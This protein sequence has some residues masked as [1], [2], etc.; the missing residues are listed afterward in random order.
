MIY[1][2]ARGSL[3]TAVSRLVNRSVEHRWTTLQPSQRQALVD[4]RCISFNR[5]SDGIAEGKPVLYQSVKDACSPLIQVV[6]NNDFKSML[7]G[8]RD[9]DN[10]TYVHS[11]RV[12]TYLALF[13]FNLRMSKEEQ[14]LLAGGGLLHDVGK[15]TIPHAVLNKPGTSRRR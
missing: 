7:Q 1:P 9:H 12:A 5:L 6:A 3:I 2:S 10:Y 4:L 11:M 14:L 15:T 8:V 13:G